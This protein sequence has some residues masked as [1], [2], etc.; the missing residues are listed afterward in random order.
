MNPELSSDLSDR[1]DRRRTRDDPRPGETAAEPR[2]PSQAT[3]DGRTSR[4]E[5]VAFKDPTDR[6]RRLIRSSARRQLGPM[7]Y[8]LLALIVLGVATTIAMAIVNP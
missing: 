3:G 7:E 2:D 8:T 6:K 5:L 4:A 1:L